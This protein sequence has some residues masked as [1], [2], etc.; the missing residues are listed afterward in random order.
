ME[1]FSPRSVSKPEPMLRGEPR[2]LWRG[3]IVEVLRNEPEG[4]RL[5][6]LLNRL[7]PQEL[8]ETGTNTD[9][10]ELIALAETLL[11]EGLI[12]RYGQIREGGVQEFDIIRLPR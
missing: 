11:E 5:G 7:V 4:I 6:E 3:R 8:F 12:E 1:L 9:R 10:R 2:R